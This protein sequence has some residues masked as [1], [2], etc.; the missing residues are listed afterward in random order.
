[1][2]DS[3][4]RGGC[5][6]PLPHDPLWQCF[7]SAGRQLPFDVNVGES[8]QINQIGMDS[9]KLLCCQKAISPKCKMLCAQTFSNDWSEARGN[10]EFDCYAQSTEIILRQCLDEGW[11]THL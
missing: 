4:D 11:Y 6:P 9:A 8:L 2:I 7:L 5:G 10:F 3:L 1:M